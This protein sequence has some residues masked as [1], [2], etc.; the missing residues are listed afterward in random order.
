MFLS[1]WTAGHFLVYHPRCLF[2]T[3]GADTA[4]KRSSGSSKNDRGFASGTSPAARTSRLRSSAR[5]RSRRS[6]AA[7]R[8]PAATRCS[9]GN[10]RM[11]HFN[12]LFFIFKEV[13]GGF[14]KNFSNIFR[15]PEM[16]VILASTISI[17]LISGN[18][19]FVKC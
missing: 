17:S 6:R 13:A 12:V 18:S 19:D 11:E 2:A 1:D 3:I 5:A 8:T 15:S 14:L 10:Y 9:Q 7:R 16:I 4:G